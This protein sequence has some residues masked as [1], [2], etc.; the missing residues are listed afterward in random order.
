MRSAKHKLKLLVASYRKN[1]PKDF[2]A[3]TEFIAEKRALSPSKFAE[4]EGS[5]S[6]RALFECPE[7]LYM[8]IISQLEPEELFWFKTGVPGDPNQGGRWFAKQFP[9]F[10][11]AREI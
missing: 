5:T 1:Y 6:S 8:D 7:T 11:L 10:A 9:F 3:V 4:L 2:K